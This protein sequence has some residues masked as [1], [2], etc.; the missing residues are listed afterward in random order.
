MPLSWNEIKHRASRFGADWKD[1]TRE[2]AERQTFWDEFFNNF[3]WPTSPTD[4]QRQAVEKS[5]Q[6]VLDARAKFPD[7]TLADLYDPVTMPPV[8]VKA[9]ADL[10]RAVERCYRKDPFPTDRSRIEFLFALYENL[11]APLVSSKGKAKSPNTA[12]TSEPRAK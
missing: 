2:A 12:T 6:A 3:P 8:L 4:A 10:D 7:S 9:H 1:E 11:T 5:A